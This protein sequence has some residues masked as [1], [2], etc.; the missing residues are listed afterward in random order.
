[1]SAIGTGAAPDLPRVRHPLEPR[2]VGPRLRG[3]A[4]HTNKF[5]STLFLEEGAQPLYVHPYV[6]R[7]GGQGSPD[8]PYCIEISYS[9]E[10]RVVAELCDGSAA[11]YLHNFV[12]DV[13]LSAADP[14]AGSAWR[15]ED[16]DEAGLGATVGFGA[17]AN[18]DNAPSWE[19]PVVR[20][21]PFVTATFANQTPV[22]RTPGGLLRVNGET[23]LAGAQFPGPRLRL[24]LASG[25]AWFLYTISV[26]ASAWHW[27]GTILACTGPLDGTVRLALDLGLQSGDVLDRHSQS[28]ATGGD[29][30]LQPAGYV[31]A[32]RKAGDGSV[33]VLQ[34]AQP[35]HLA[36]LELSGGTSSQLTSLK[37]ASTT[38]GS[39]VAVAADQWVL[40]AKMLDVAWLPPK[41]PDP[42]LTPE[43]LACLREDLAPDLQ[44]EATAI[45]SN[46]FAG[47]VLFRF[48]QAVLVADA[49]GE[50]ALRDAAA[51]RLQVALAEFA[52]GRTANPLR[53]DEVWGGVVAS[54]G[55]QGDKLCDFGNSYYNDHHYHWGYFL[56]AA[57][58]ARRFVPSFAGVDAWI[59]ALIRDAANASSADGYFPLWRTFDWY[60]GHSWSQGLFE[61]A[62]G[63]DQESVSEEAM[64]HY[65]CQLW[66]AATHDAALEARSRLTLSVAVQAVQL[67]FFMRPGVGIHPDAFAKNKVTGIFFENKVHYTTWFSPRRE[68]IHGI[69]VLPVTPVTAYLRPQAFMEEE[70]RER[71]Q[72][73]LPNVTDG[74]RSLL[75]LNLAMLDPSVAYEGL[76]TC[77][78]DGGVLRSWALFWAATR[79][80]VQPL[81]A[82]FVVTAAPPAPPAAAGRPALAP[83]GPCAWHSELDCKLSLVGP[84]EKRHLQI[85]I[86][87]ANAHGVTLVAVHYSINGGPQWNFDV[88]APSPTGEWLHTGGDSCGVPALAIGDAVSYWVYILRDGVGEE[89]RGLSWTAQAPGS[90]GDGGAPLAFAA[91]TPLQPNFLCALSLVGTSARRC[92]QII[93]QPTNPHGISL[94]AVHYS[95]NGGPQWN[96]DIHM[97]ERTGEWVHR[98]SDFPGAPAVTS[99]DVVSYWVYAIRHGLGEEVRGLSWTVP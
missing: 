40:N 58:V 13:S 96:S 63:K 68:C 45:G 39:M 33:P 19:A 92:L 23:P 36:A 51:G 34:C 85:S 43:I 9:A 87:P 46:Y 12:V 95:I 99:G 74:W 83:A 28:W 37:F 5:F 79:P 31:I 56:G 29:V 82:G 91:P 50:T 38:K 53:Y 18:S 8:C 97:P 24:E 81:T 21:M 44:A 59:A 69:Q 1:M 20:G 93:V 62:D 94:V 78:L 67:Y 47:K 3:R 73:V 98:G 75:L 16:T 55:L 26:Q 15:V 70:W 71:L 48:A 25:R 80:P 54:A 52:A 30:H 32:W 89:V 65:G 7:I 41:S 64:F 57:A 11:F 4:L 2:R 77:A 90:C 61:S 14:D 49:L 35:H 86:K 6:L 27:D 10:H 84:P 66:G 60:S 42:A 76:R 88:Q 72:E 17:T 22:V